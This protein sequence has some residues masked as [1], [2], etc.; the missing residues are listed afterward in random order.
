MKKKILV[1]MLV[2]LAVIAHSEVIDR[3]IAKVGNDIIL[4]SD[5][6]KQIMQM[7]SA[8]VIDD[9]IS[10]EDI[11]DQMIEFKLI[12]QKA[13]ELDYVV[14]K[15]Q[16]SEMANKRLAEI[17]S[18]FKSET[19][20]LAELKKSGMNK[21]DLLDYFEEMFEEQS[22][23]EQVVRYEIESKIDIS[24][25][26]IQ[27]YYQDN[28]ID[29]PLRKPSYKLGMI[30]SQIIPSTKTREER[31]SQLED[32]LERINRGEDFA[33]LA[34][35]YS[36]C[37][38]SASGGDLG[39][40]GR[41]EMVKEFENTAFSMKPGEVS[42]IVETQ[43]GYHIIKLQD[44]KENKVR[45]SHILKD[46]TPTKKDSL[47][48]KKVM[49]NVLQRYKDGEDFGEL[50]LNYSDDKESSLNDG[51]IGIY[52]H[53][54]YPPLY[55]EYYEKLEPSQVSD[56][57]QIQDMFYIFANL[58]DVPQGVYQL[59]EI[60]DKIKDMARAEKRQNYYNKWIEDLKKEIYVEIT[61]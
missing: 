1:L 19:E 44:I 24:E 46:L 26:E 3:I 33:E 57:V 55:K 23:R 29:L 41:G 18:Q 37:P 22:L 9:E 30:V 40:F 50:A 47:A 35:E 49:M 27:Q 52:P 31:Y 43:F 54:E 28:I 5:L 13:K 21:F 4:E 51:I 48:M 20:F 2:L 8:G 39:Y 12:I 17:E 7:K 45:A 38:S 15:N 56:V 42:D 16:I 32:I 53:G 6:T 10:N 25:D 36:D 60:R 11:L 34:K 14:D 58:E 59:E 61:Y